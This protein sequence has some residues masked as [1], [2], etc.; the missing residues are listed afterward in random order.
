MNEKEM[1][2]MKT[3]NTLI[4]E[5]KTSETLQKLLA[6]AFKNNLLAA[7]LKEQGC[8]TTAEE[9]ISALKAQANQVDDDSLDA[10]AGGANA[11]EAYV[12][13]LTFGICCLVEYINSQKRKDEDW[14]DG[15]LLCDAS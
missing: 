9:F 10:V 13:V 5:I 6:D 12:S 7:F 15:R 1:Y 2:T 11:K 14:G 3:I 4:E 8:D